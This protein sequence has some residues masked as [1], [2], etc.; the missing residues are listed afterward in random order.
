M[1]TKQVPQCLSF[2]PSIS[3]HSLRDAKDRFPGRPISNVLLR[4]VQGLGKL[5]GEELLELSQRL[6]AV[7]F[8]PGHT[9]TL[10]QLCSAASVT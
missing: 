3:N 10:R 5:N 2:R 8:G 7:G 9:C 6:R 4:L 1:Y